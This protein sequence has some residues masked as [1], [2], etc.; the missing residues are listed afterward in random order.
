M[1]VVC[2]DAVA[3][4][5]NDQPS[6]AAFPIGMYHDAVGRSA[7]R[8]SHGCLQ[9][10]TGMNGAFTRKWVRPPAECTHEP[11]FDGPHAG[12]NMELELAWIVVIQSGNRRTL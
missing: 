9:V 12:P 8:R 6:V 2:L 4:I 3:V 10:D 7:H 5:D 1:P 11:P